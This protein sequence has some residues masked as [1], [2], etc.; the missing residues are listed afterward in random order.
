M[1]EGGK[2]DKTYRVPRNNSANGPAKSQA[3]RCNEKKNNH[4]RFERGG[5]D[6]FCEV[7]SRCHVVMPTEKRQRRFASEIPQIMTPFEKTGIL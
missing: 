7:Y 6:V 3:K 5:V 2:R 1:E 4:A